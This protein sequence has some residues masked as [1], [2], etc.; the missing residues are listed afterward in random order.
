MDPV[1]NELYASALSFVPYLIAAYALM[2]VV[3]F[4]YIIYSHRGL[5]KTEKH[6]TALE[7]AIN[8]LQRKS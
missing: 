2:W 1:L 4:A 3:L 8:Q 6:I 7:E 5:A